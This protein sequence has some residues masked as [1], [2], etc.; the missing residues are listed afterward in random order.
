MPLRLYCAQSHPAFGGSAPLIGL[1]SLALP[2]ARHRRDKLSYAPWIVCP[3][4]TSVLRSTA[5]RLR[6]V[7][8][9][10]R[11]CVAYASA[12]PS[13]AGQAELRSV[14]HRLGEA[15]QCT[16]GG[17]QIKPAAAPPYPP[18]NRGP[19]GRAVSRVLFHRRGGR[20]A[21]GEGHFSGPRLAAGLFPIAR[22]S[23]LPGAVGR[24]PRPGR[25]DRRGGRR[26]PKAPAWPCT[27]WGLPCRPAHT[28]R[29]ALLPHHFTLTLRR[30]AGRGASPEARAMEGGV[31]SV[32]LS[33]SRAAPRGLTGRWALPTTVVQRCSDFPPPSDQPRGAAFRASG[34]SIIPRKGAGGARKLQRAAESPAIAASSTR[35]APRRPPSP[36][37]AP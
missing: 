17:A 11:P 14:R 20:R 1:T 7:H 30:P 2:Y 18:P 31:F 8:A 15:R 28:G 27:R 29:G 13:P 10:D 9:A 32:A 6:R 24:E 22:E 4:A 37:P 3:A 35:S 25:G 16:A 5:P 23:G 33:R 36:S 21:G 19:A 26:R 12:S 34:T